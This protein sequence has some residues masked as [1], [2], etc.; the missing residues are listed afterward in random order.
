M[1]A[2]VF[3]GNLTVLV[4]GFPTQ[5]IRIQRGLKQGDTINPYLFLLVFEG[6]SGLVASAKEIG[7]YSRFRVN[8]SGLVSPHLQYIDDTLLVVET[9]LDEF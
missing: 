6:L 5:E 2:Y 7:L 9:S 4:N 1:K 3:A 8:T